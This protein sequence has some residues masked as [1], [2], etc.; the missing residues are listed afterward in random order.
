MYIRPRHRRGAYALAAEHTLPRG[1]RFLLFIGAMI[2]VAYLLWTLFLRLLGVTSGVERAGA[3]L[4]VEDRGTV[5]VVIDGKQQRAENGMMVF[6]GESVMTGPSAHASMQFFDG[7]RVRLADATDV[8][9]TESSRGSK[10][11]ITLGLQQGNI[12]MMTAGRSF[13]GSVATTVT[14]PTLSFAVTSGTEAQLSPTSVTVFS[15]ENT[16]VEVSLT[17]HDSF[18]IGEGQQWLLPTNAQVGDNVFEYRSPID[19]AVARSTFIVESRVLLMNAMR[20]R[21]SS[22]SRASENGELLTITAPANGTIV[23]TPTVVVTGTVGAGVTRLQ[24]NG[25]PALLDTVKKTFSQEVAPSEGQGDFEIAVQAMDDARTIL[26]EAHRTVKRAPAAPLGAPSITIPARAGDTYRTHAEELIVRGT[27]PAG[28]QGIMVNDYKLQLFEPAK[29]EWSYVASLRLKNMVQG[30]N[31]YDVFA[32]DST[33]KKSEP[34]RLIIIQG[35]DGP[36]GIVSAASS[37]AAFAKPASSSSPANNA[38]L[39]PGSLSVTL[40]ETGTTHTETGTGF[41]MIGAT[42]PKTATISVNDYT[43]QLY[44]PGKTVWNYIV[45]AAINNLRR[46]KNTYTIVA[47]NKEGQILDTLTY[48]V[49]YEPTTR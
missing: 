34:A 44:R 25:Y 2:F 29:G 30:T 46:G 1:V 32:L 10:G 39:E 41:L 4:T 23:S 15:S 9:I 20:G 26:A 21:A 7:T 27:A 17:G 22:G 40:P 13:T 33:G 45:D 47:R 16:G 31:T 19:P 5:N 28:T 12:W 18:V 48:T 43:L 35:G 38:P 49:Q 6:P 8:A 3:F 24:I 11:K 14:S 42:S 37:S 36:D